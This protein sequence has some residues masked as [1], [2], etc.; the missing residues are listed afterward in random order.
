MPSDKFTTV[1]I[2]D[3]FQ[4]NGDGEI[5]EEARISLLHIWFFQKK[6]LLWQDIFHLLLNQ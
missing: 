2:R 3:Y 1:N 6:M 5:S 4:K